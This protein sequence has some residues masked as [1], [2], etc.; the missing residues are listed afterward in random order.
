M[1]HKDKYYEEFNSLGEDK[2]REL[3][4]TWDKHRE[5]YYAQAW[6]AEKER[7]RVQAAVE[8]QQWDTRESLD[9]AKDG[10]KT[11]KKA[12]TFSMLKWLIPPAAIGAIWWVRWLA[13]PSL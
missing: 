6:L 4:P 7:K 1:A 8:Q 13:E 5:G 3:L 11:A 10:N 9:I 12:L 2:V